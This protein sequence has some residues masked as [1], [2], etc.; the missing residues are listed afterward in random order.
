MYY[1]R[2]AIFRGQKMYA[3]QN[4]C[5]KKSCD[6]WDQQKCTDI[7]NINTKYLKAK[8]TNSG[9]LFNMDKPNGLVKNKVMLGCIYLKHQLTY[10][11]GL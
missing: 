7:W 5:D 10:S 2:S 4:K 3:F 8:W 9:M 11:K 1:Q 6:Y